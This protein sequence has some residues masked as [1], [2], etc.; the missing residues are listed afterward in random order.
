M[1][2]PANCYP[3]LCV[4]PC[5][6]PSI[7]FDCALIVTLVLA[8]EGFLRVML[9]VRIFSTAGGKR[10]QTGYDCITSLLCILVLFEDRSPQAGLHRARFRSLVLFQDR[11]ASG[12]A[13]AADEDPL[14]ALGWI[15]DQCVNLLLG[16][17]AE[18]T[19]RN[20]LSYATLAEHSPSM[21]RA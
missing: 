16:S 3:Y 21:A 11:I 6:I 8:H 20:F 19:S 9:G 17:A 18:R 15:G 12:D 7:S 5:S 1:P 4:S 14:G 13:L 10:L 2:L